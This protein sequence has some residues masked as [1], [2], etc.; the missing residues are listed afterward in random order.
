MASLPSSFGRLQNRVAIVTGASG[1]IGRAIALAYAREG[2]TVVNADIK[3]VG[4][5][6]ET[7]THKAIQEGGWK[8][9]FVKTD[10]GDSAS[11]KGLVERAVKEFSRVDM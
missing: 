5:P 3:D 2:A 6:N 9:I 8:S 11:M 1:G 4:S 7:P 10:V